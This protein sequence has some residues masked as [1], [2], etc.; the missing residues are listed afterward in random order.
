MRAPLVA[1][2]GLGFAAAV[3]SSGGFNGRA[4]SPL[5]ALRGGENA[6]VAEFGHSGAPQKLRNAFKITVR[7][8]PPCYLAAHPDV[9][10]SPLCPVN[11][12]DEPVPSHGVEVC[13]TVT[14]LFQLSVRTEKN[15]GVGADW[16]PPGFKWVHRF[17]SRPADPLFARREGVPD[18]AMCSLALSLFQ[19]PL[20]LLP[21]L[22]LRRPR[23]RQSSEAMRVLN[24]APCNERQGQGVRGAFAN[25]FCELDGITNPS[26]LFPE[27]KQGTEGATRECTVQGPIL[28][29]SSTPSAPPHA[30]FPLG[31]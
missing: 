6:D 22:L 24:A 10:T 3:S 17:K 15:V 29:V 2:L 25:A 14:I 19:R 30:S 27:S 13:G 28:M 20:L 12:L 21:S 8:L 31:P 23:H 9:F 16:P 18:I 5:R 7:A 11:F 1:L 26:C 4:I